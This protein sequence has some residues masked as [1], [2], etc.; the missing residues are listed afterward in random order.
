M[1]KSFSKNN[2]DALHRMIGL[3]AYCFLSI[4]G[5]AQPNS[6][7]KIILMDGSVIKVHIHQL[8]DS[9]IVLDN[10]LQ[11]PVSEIKAIKVNSS[12]LVWGTIG[13][14]SLYVGFSTVGETD[15]NISF[16]QSVGYGMMAGATAGVIFALIPNRTIINGKH[17][18]YERKKRKLQRHLDG[19]LDKII[20]A[21]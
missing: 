10:Q 7:S 9:A 11:Y 18:R 3:V 4:S 2:S 20:E 1:Q 16:L 13:L 21:L 14:T 19:N 6:K 15:M 12:G 5:H 8:K 17:K